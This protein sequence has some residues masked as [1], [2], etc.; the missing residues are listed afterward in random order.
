[1]ET[2]FLDLQPEKETGC[3]IKKMLV[4]FP[5][6]HGGCYISFVVLPIV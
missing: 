3:F 5:F 1:M 6:G 4:P 2:I